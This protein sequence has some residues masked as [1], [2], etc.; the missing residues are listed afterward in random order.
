MFTTET[1]KHMSMNSNC[2][3]LQCCNCEKRWPF[4]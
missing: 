4:L 2:N 3:A 1:E